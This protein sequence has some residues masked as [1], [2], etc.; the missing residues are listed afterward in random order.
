M[1]KSSLPQCNACI[2]HFTDAPNILVFQHFV[3]DVCFHMCRQLLCI[4]HDTFTHLDVACSNGDLTT[5]TQDYKKSVQIMTQANVIKKKRKR[6]KTP[7]SKQGTQVTKTGLSRLELGKRG[8]DFQKCYCK[9][10]G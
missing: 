2:Q 4:K 6:M 9:S 10:L 1:G 3:C 5:T 8:L 7:I